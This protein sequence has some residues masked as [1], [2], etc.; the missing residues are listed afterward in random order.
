VTGMKNIK[1]KLIFIL[2]VTL[3]AIY[4]SLPESLPVSINLP[5]IAVNQVFHK[6]FLNKPLLLGLD[7]VG[8]ARLT[9]EADTSSLDSG[10]R[11]EA[12][13]ALQNVI[14]RRVNLFGVSESNV[15]LS[16]FE[17]KDRVIVE[18]PGVSDTKQA[19][20]VVGQTAQL[21]FDEVEG[22]SLK[23]T[24]LTGAELKS[25]QLSFDRVGGKPVVSLTFTD[26]GAKKFADLTAK[27]IGKAIPIVLDGEVISAPLVNEKIA[28]GAAQISGSFTEEQARELAVQLNA[29]ALPIP[30]KLIEERTIGATLGTAAIQQS[31]KAGI[32]G[33]VLVLLFMLL[34]YRK[35]G[36]FADIA[37]L[38]F[39]LIS[40][41]P[42]SHR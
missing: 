11:E 12:L 4:I 5:H 30:V 34:V 18:L 37:L 33:V 15:L 10:R 17:G 24:D 29:G 26:S 6:T 3:F 40:F 19:I 41:S 16:R 42:I 2:V 8:G 31:V 35:L 36:I 20:S 22:Q 28:D 25:A 7:L 9:F 38:V 39:A 23:K 32:V 13:T 1:R 21:E 14:E 27:N